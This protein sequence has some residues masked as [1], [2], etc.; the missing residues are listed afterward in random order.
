MQDRPPVN[1]PER[2]LD[3][4]R[5]PCAYRYKRLGLVCPNLPWFTVRRSADAERKAR[6]ACPE[7]L[8]EV[9]WQMQEDYGRYDGEY[10]LTARDLPQ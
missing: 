1:G 3:T 8:H 9:I 5:G 10:V 6:M 4:R 2:A 7:H